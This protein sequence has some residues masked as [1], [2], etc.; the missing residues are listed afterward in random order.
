M[1]H[2]DEG[3]IHAWLDGAL[4]TAEASRVEQHV[5]QCAECADMVADARGLI[6]GASRI[7]SALDVVPGGVIPKPGA[8][9]PTRSAWRALRL[10]P[11]RA[12]LAATL[13]IA[14]ASLLVVRADRKEIAESASDTVE[15]VALPAA[16]A[17]PSGMI[18]RSAAA[19]AGKVATNDARGCYVL[20]DTTT[21]PRSLP[22]RFM[23]AIDSTASPHHNVVRGVGDTGRETP[24]SL[25]EWIAAGADA[26]VVFR[27]G[28]QRLVYSLATGTPSYLL[29]T[30][31]GGAPIQTRIERTTCSR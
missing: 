24:P 21:W 18:M 3:T 10:S 20:I 19:L 27:A 13:M 29:Q 30:V 12:A 26:I 14:A 23:L 16:S 17:P 5:A 7:V 2:L 6:A 8:A 11:L 1:Q 28:D 25:G 31:V 22:T 9:A 4:S 15:L